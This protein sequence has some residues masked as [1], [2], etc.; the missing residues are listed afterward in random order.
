MTSRRSANF[1]G[2][3]NMPICRFSSMVSEGNTLFVWG[4]KPTPLVTSLSD[5]SPMTL[6]PFTVIDPERTLTMPNSDLSSVDLPAP[7]GPMMP[8][9]SP[10]N[11]SSEHRLRML[12]S[13]T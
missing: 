11:S 12:T 8:T 2:R 3:R 13:G 9:S 6:S 4:T 7:F 1:L 5:L 10:S